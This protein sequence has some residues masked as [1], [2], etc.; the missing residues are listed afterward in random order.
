MSR[1]LLFLFTFLITGPAAADLAVES[2]F[3]GGSAEVVSIDQ[4]AS[5]VVLNPAN[6]PDRGWRCWWYFRLTGIT[7]GKAITL[8]V[9]D[10]PWATPKRATFSSDGGKTW[11]HSEEG[12]RVGKR[13]RYS[14]TFDTETALV[15]WGPP[16]LPDDAR[17]LVEAL[18]AGSEEATVFSLCRTREG[19][20]TPALRIGTAG[21]PLIWVQARQHAWESGASWV[22]KGFAEW[23]VS[24]ALE[25]SGLRERHE[26]VFVPVMDIDN[27]HR[28]AGGKSQKPQDHNR[29]WSDAPHWN[30]VA[31]AQKAIRAAAGQERLAMFIDLHNP[32]AGD[33]FPYFYVPPA[34][35][36]SDGAVSNHARFIE[37]AKTE[38]TGPLRFTGRIIESGVKYDPR[39]W[40]T[41]SKNWVALLGT[42][43]VSVTLETSWNT[44][45]ST[46]A[47]YE[48]VGRQLG[49][50]IS[51]YA[52]QRSELP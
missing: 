42:P 44:P 23:V 29:D 33:L 22:G 3:P 17:A 10:A 48:T 28:G 20:D 14:L 39:A 9:G 35:I 51:R 7:P 8:E 47:G 19:H 27:A 25:A 46:T 26:I 12:T 40:K 16:F 45:V 52:H 15:A 32:G 50:A 30:A 2:D 41:I 43:A 36:L 37:A 34:E 5:A 24:D 6:Y 11:H 31:A 49:L 21:K 1:L 38:I 4:A 13:I 18:A